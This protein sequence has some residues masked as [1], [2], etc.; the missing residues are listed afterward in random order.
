MKLLVVDD[1]PINQMLVERMLQNDKRYTIFHADS[2][3][4]AIEML[5]KE[6]MDIVLLDILMPQMDGFTTALEIQK[7]SA[8]RIIFATADAD[9]ATREKAHAVGVE[10]LLVKPFRRDELLA[11]LK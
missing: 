9:D 6:D 4:E 7:I 8:P 2:G 1:E 3:K 10:E 5:S 11:A